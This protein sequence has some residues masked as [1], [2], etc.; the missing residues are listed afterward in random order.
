[1]AMPV[2]TYKYLSEYLE[3]DREGRE[4]EIWRDEFKNTADCSGYNMSEDD[5]VFS[6]ERERERC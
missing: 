5:R 1:M 2:N 6:L 4:R 3:R